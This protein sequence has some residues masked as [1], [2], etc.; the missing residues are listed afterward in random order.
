MPNLKKTRMAESM[1]SRYCGN[2]IARNLVAQQDGKMDPPPAY[3]LLRSFQ[4]CVG[5]EVDVPTYS[6]IFLSSRQQPTAAN[7]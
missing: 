1:V 7:T 5:A 4:G 3:E 6:C 2:G